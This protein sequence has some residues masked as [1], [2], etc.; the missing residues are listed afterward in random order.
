MKRQENWLIYRTSRVSYVQNY[1][2]VVLLITL[3]LQVLPM[4]DS[5]SRFY[6][7]FLIGTVL[8]VAW[9]LEEPELERMTRQYHITG[10]E[11]M[12][13][14]GIFSKKR[15]VITYSNVS[16]IDVVKSVI[17]RVFNYGDIIIV[18]PDPSIKIRMNGMRNP[19][20]LY[21]IINSKVSKLVGHH[22]KGEEE[23]E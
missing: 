2:L 12:M 11:V 15:R 21:R 18:G 14:E 7:I 13:V 3:L 19:D 4:L 22:R 8:L 5:R 9:L 10:G 17:G 20:E 16:N 1:L 6:S 23:K